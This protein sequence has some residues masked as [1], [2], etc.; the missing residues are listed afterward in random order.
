M[1]NRFFPWR[2]RIKIHIKCRRNHVEIPK[3]EPR[4]TSHL[5]LRLELLALQP[6]GDRHDILDLAGRRLVACTATVL[7]SVRT[8]PSAQRSKEVTAEGRGAYRERRGGSKCAGTRPPAPWTRARRGRRPGTTMRRRGGARGLGF[9]GGAT[10]RAWWCSR[11]APRG[12]G[13]GGV[14]VEM[15]DASHGLQNYP[16]GFIQNWF[17]IQKKLKI[18]KNRK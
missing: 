2:K 9:G 3:S 11:V 10:W 18:H 1:S 5:E 14:G 17:Q 13:A 4:V 16:P 8:R 6:R 12:G 7:R 15:P